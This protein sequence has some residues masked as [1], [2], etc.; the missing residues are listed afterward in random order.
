MKK[1]TAFS[2]QLSIVFALLLGATTAMQ[3]QFS[4]GNGDPASPYIVTTPAQLDEV[5]NYL[6]KRITVQ[7]ICGR[8]EQMNP[9]KSDK[10]K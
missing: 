4:D 8:N 10:G 9:Q 7:T 2:R 5:R 6:D 3:A 1:I